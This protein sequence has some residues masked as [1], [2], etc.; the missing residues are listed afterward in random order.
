M[1]VFQILSLLI[2][3]AAGC[4]YLN[5]RLLRLP[6]TIGVMLIALAL[7]LVLIAIDR[8]G[9]H[10][11]DRAEYIVSRIDLEATL[12]EGMLGALLFAG[13]LHVNLEDL[14]RQKWPITSFATVGVLLSTAMV[15]LATYYLLPLFGIGLPLIYCL[16]FGALIAP[17]DPIAVL[18]ILKQVGAPKNIET[19]ITGESLFND[20]IGVVVFLAMLS[21][22]DT[23]HGGP[24]AGHIGLLF[25]KEAVGGIVLGLVIGLFT[26]YLLKKVDNYQVEVLVTLAVV[27]GG[28]AL[29]LWLHTSGPLAMVVAGLLIGNHGRALAMS[30]LTRERLDG[31]WELIDEVLNAVLFVL[32]GLELLVV[33]MRG[34]DVLAGLILIPVVLSARFISI[35][36]PVT[37]IRRWRPLSPH[38]VKLLTWAGLRG[39]ISVA[40]ALSLP[41]GPE[42]NV[43]LTVTYVIVV[44]SIVVQ[45]LTTG[46]VVR[47]LVAPAPV[48]SASS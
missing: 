12:L 6:G 4:A 1:T 16:L 7:S 33:E 27:T 29:A 18:G 21:F 8:L 19:K 10:L 3:L 31:F 20:G 23:S 39:G 5:Y 47:R 41:A 45:G 34:V 14:E 43:L 30:D 13:A 42:R 28:Y 26:Y 48:A 44:F 35:G 2:T 22:V 11:V 46:R 37:I 32:L 9:I 24:S 36:I 15:G 17:T 38:V 40:L 25:I